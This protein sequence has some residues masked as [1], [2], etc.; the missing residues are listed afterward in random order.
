MSARNF[1]PEALRASGFTRLRRRQRRPGFIRPAPPARRGGAGKR[2]GF[3]LVEVLVVIA[4]IAILARL[5]LAA[6]GQA[7]IQGYTAVCANNLHQLGTAF[8]L[9][10]D[11]WGCYPASGDQSSWAGSANWVRVGNQTA[12]RDLNPNPLPGCSNGIPWSCSPM[13]APDAR[14]RTGLG[15]YANPGNKPCRQSIYWCPL[16]DSNSCWIITYSMNS[17]LMNPPQTGASNTMGGDYNRW[18]VKPENVKHPSATYLLFEERTTTEDPSYGQRQDGN[19]LCFSNSTCDPNFVK[20]H[21]RVTKHH[22]GGSNVLYCDGHVKWASSNTVECDI[23]QA[24]GCTI[25]PFGNYLS[26]TLIGHGD[27]SDP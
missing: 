9:Y 20:D 7:K 18:G 26:G 16:D 12:G 23:D 24:K 10:T 4:I 2:G 17:S 14:Y 5:L 13:S 3:T 25:D 6:L 27:A 15:N 22:N 11:N 1:I 19:F 21:D 8:T